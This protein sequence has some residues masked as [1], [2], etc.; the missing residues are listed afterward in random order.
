MSFSF[1]SSRLSAV[2]RP[3]IWYNPMMSGLVLRQHDGVITS[4]MTGCTTGLPPDGLVTSATL[5][6]GP[7][8][9]PN[10]LQDGGIL[11]HEMQINQGVNPDVA[12]IRARVSTNAQELTED[13]NVL[14][15]FAGTRYN[16]PVGIVLM[17]PEGIISTAV[18]DPLTMGG[19]RGFIFRQGWK[20][21]ILVGKGSELLFY[22]YWYPRGFCD[23]VVGAAPGVNFGASAVRDIALEETPEAFLKAVN[24]LQKWIDQETRARIYEATIQDASESNRVVDQAVCDSLIMEIRDLM[25]SRNKIYGLRFW[26]AGP[27]QQVVTIVDP[28]KRDRYVKSLPLRIPD[29][30][31]DRMREILVSIGALPFGCNVGELHFDISDRGADAFDRAVVRISIAGNFSMHE[32]E[33]PAASSDPTTSNHLSGQFSYSFIWNSRGGRQY[34]GIECCAPDS[35]TQDL[36]SGHASLANRDL[37]VF[38]RWIKYQNELLKRKSNKQKF[39]V[40]DAELLSIMKEMLGR[41]V[42][43]EQ[44]AGCQAQCPARAG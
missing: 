14:E 8:S 15:L 23:Q 29:A 32:N 9:A 24:K 13:C 11:I 2:R 39:V 35:F 1:R 30:V 5:V 42:T 28:G 43:E 21:Q 4:G 20:M 16:A 27:Q 36:S 38:L 25:R 40:G 19:L 3:I 7:E 10:L 12:E 41:R 17:S 37:S 26:N 34:G 22:D 6:Y 33:Y 18:Y 44:K 31:R